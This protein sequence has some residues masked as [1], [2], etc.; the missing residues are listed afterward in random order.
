MAAAG[1]IA[2]AAGP[3]IGGAVTTYFSWRRVFAGE[4]VIVLGIS[5][6]PAGSRMPAG[7][8]TALDVV[9]ARALGGRAGPVV[10]GVLRSSEWGWVLPKEAPSLLGLSLT[11]GFIVG[12]LIVV[13]IFLV[14]GRASRARPGAAGRAVDARATPS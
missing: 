1:A 14:G 3:L 13:W 4:V 11:F 9:G 8:R 10:F 6:W 5:C 12:G 2:V 7:G